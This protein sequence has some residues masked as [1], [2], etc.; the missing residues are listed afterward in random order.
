MTMVGTRTTPPTR[1]MKLT[2][3]WTSPTIRLDTIEPMPWSRN[4]A[5]VGWPT[6]EFISASDRIHRMRP[7]ADDGEIEPKTVN[8]RAHH[9]AMT[10]RNRPSAPPAADHDNGAEP[11]PARPGCGPTRTGARA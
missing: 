11:C 7:D 10:S 9:G 4:V 1:T 5:S 6:I 2:A 8:W 3:A